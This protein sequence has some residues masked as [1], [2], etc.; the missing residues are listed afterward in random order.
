MAD[1]PLSALD[2]SIQSK[3]LNLISDI[4]KKTQIGY[5]FISHDFG[6]VR[7]L[8]DRVAVLYLGQLMEVSS[9]DGIFATPSHPY[10]QALIS[11]VPIPGFRV[12]KAP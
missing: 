10:T 1:E 12:A 6:V 4:Q 3:I 8:A 7:H 5:V 11:S 2:V 9:A